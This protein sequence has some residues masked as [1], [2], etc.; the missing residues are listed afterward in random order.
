MCSSDLP[1]CNFSLLGVDD[2]HD[3]AALKFFVNIHTR[4]PPGLFSP[5]LPLVACAGIIY[6]IL[7]S[8]IDTNQNIFM[9]TE[10]LMLLRQTDLPLYLSLYEA[11]KDRIASG[12][13]SAGEKLPLDFLRV[14]NDILRGCFQPL[15]LGNLDQPVRLKQQQRARFVRRIVRNRDRRAVG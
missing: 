12:E 6:A 13:F 11:I 7:S 8:L 1:L 15:P 2:V 10:A 4:F 14:V 9:G 3:D 5:A